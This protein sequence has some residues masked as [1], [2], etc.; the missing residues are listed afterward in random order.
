MLAGNSHVLLAAH[1]AVPFAGGV[2]VALNTRVTAA[3]MAYILGHAGCSVFIYDT[4]F[5]ATATQAVKETG[6]GV[7]ALRAGGDRDEL[8]PLIAAG[9]PLFAAG[10][11]R[12]R[13]C[14]RST[15]RAGPPRGPRA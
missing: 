3:D 12:A 11:R 10:H 9:E 6:G 15:T 7:R 14:S 1:Y 13:R 5:A 4:E 2:L 8:E